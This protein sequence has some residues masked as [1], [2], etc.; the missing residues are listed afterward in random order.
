MQKQEMIMVN[1][2]YKEIPQEIKE[3]IFTN[4][5]VKKN[6]RIERIISKGHSSAENF[7]YDQEQK[8]WVLVLKGHAILVFKNEA[9]QL[10]LKSGDYVNIPAHK[11]HRVKWTDPQQ[12][13]IWL[14]IYC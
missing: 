8:E 1:N 3:E 6:V 7:W 14:A 2:I 5:L 11:Q 13:T 9:Q 10:E 12:E 4:L